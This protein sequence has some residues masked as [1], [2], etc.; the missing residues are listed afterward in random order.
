MNNFFINFFQISKTTLI[1][2]STSPVEKEDI[3]KFSD[4]I[5]EIVNSPLKG[6]VNIQPPL[7]VPDTNHMML[8]PYCP[9]TLPDKWLTTATKLIDHIEYADHFKM[10]NTDCESPVINVQIENTTGITVE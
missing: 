10:T 2:S 8:R 6:I 5:N 7:E 9:P 3:K 1:F 4:T